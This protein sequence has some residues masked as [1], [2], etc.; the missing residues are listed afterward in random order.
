METV[1]EGPFPELS[2]YNPGMR[3][4][5]RDL[6]STNADGRQ[7]AA[8][9]MSLHL[10][11]NLLLSALF[12]LVFVLGAALVIH[13]ARKAVQDEME[14]T[15]RL[16]LQL[17]EISLEELDQPAQDA[18]LSRLRENLGRLVHTRHLRLEFQPGS[19]G[20]SPVAV[21]PVSQ[22]EARAPQWFNRLVWPQDR[23]LR[24]ALKQPD[25]PHGSIVI[26][27]DPA[28]EISEAWKEARVL[29]GLLALALVLSLV[30]VHLAVGH[31]LRPV[32]TIL[33]ALEEIGEGNYRV[34]LSSLGTPELDQ[35]ALGVNGMA[36]ALEQSREENLQLT[37]QALHIR[38]EERRHLAH[39]LHDELGQSLSAIRAVAA[40]I[41]QADPEEPETARRGART[42]SGIA[43]Q[44]YDVVRG[45]M[46]RLRPV[47][48][49]ELGLVPAL[50]EM[51]DDWN[52]RHQEAFCSLVIEGELPELDDDT[53]INLYRIVQEALTNAARHSGASDVSVSMAR[54]VEGLRLVVEDDGRGFDPAAV[55][56]GLGLLGI[57]ERV[58]ALDGV[59]TLHSGPGQGVRIEVE[60]PLHQEG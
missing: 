23:S 22:R 39:E 24:Y 1:P 41:D 60:I 9:P 7:P 18:L 50:Q 35:I 15:A 14:S 48:L 2:Q 27:A 49:D 16:T 19:P 46:R 55:K 44:I 29:L 37:R 12:L 43:G 57:E 28:D 40:T 11:L 31:W 52:G 38:E 21:T 32:A 34:R 36:R 8:T 5:S 42:I 58:G 54:T 3:Y 59:F 13:N 33:G 26:W 20:Q 47:V 4:F 45:M 53:R 56:R 25:S 10:R 6:S 30:T 51:V 17:L